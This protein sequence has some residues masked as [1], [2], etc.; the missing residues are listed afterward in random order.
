MTLSLGAP[1]RLARPRARCTERRVTQLLYLIA[2]ARS[3]FELE[4]A[5]EL[6]HFSFEFLDALDRL[7][8]RH[9]RR[10]VR[11]VALL[12]LL[13]RARAFHHIPNRLD[14]AARRDAVRGVELDLLVA[15]AVGLRDGALDRARPDIR[16]QN[17]LALHIAG[18]PA[19]GLDQ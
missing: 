18:R 7:F 19:D 16:I 2:Q 15:P 5:R 6:H 8:G 13:D 17:C 12:P 11:A 9:D 10:V 14:D 1:T 3:L 4:I